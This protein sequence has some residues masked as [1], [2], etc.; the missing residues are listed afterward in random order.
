MNFNKVLLAGHL[1]R[2]PD[3]RYTGSGT[4]VAVFGLAVNRTW[5]GQDGQRKEEA[6]FVDC[7]TWGKQAET[8][9]EYLRKGS[10]LFV[11]GRLRLDTWEAK[12]GGGKRSKLKVV[13]E[14]FQFLGK[15]QDS[16]SQGERGGRRET[17]RSERRSTPPPVDPA[18]YQDDENIPF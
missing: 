5:T 14:R 4:A 18:D 17:G 3:L 11:E 9:N 16:D 15:G 7:E 12:D 10:P 13:V 6:T 1:T 2:S 8:L